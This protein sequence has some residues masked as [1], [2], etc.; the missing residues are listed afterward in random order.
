VRVCGGSRDLE[1]LELGGV[2]PPALLLALGGSSSPLSSL[3]LGGASW[4]LQQQA[5]NG[6]AW[7]HGWSAGNDCLAAARAGACMGAI[8]ALQ[9]LGSSFLYTATSTGC[10]QA[11][12]CPSPAVS[13][14][15]GVARIL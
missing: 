3:S 2:V 8:N 1:G 15:A 7:S 9:D 5:G 6:T 12:A 13:G 4:K 11:L 10:M 14:C